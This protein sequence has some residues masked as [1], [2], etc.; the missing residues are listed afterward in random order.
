MHEES[1]NTILV[2]LQY[3]D[4]KIDRMAQD[5]S[6]MRQRLAGLELQFGAFVG[7]EQSHY[8]VVMQRLD[9]IDQRLSRIERKQDLVDGP[10][11]SGP[12][13]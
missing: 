10:S 4:A 11:V 7:A 13:I 9:S 8:A 1:D 5:M 2:Y 3:L 6:E 12:A